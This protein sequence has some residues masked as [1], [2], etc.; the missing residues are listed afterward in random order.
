MSSDQDREDPAQELAMQAAWE[1]VMKAHEQPLGD[2][3]LD[4]LNRW[5][6]ADPRHRTAHAQA[7][8]LWL[9]SGLVPPA[10]DDDGLPH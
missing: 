7:S 2:V 5:L 4:A 6:D 9:L 1:W 8:R 3:E 10:H